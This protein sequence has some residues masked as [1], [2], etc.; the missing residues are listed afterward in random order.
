[1]RARVGL[2]AHIHVSENPEISLY[3]QGQE[4]GIFSFTTASRLALLLSNRWALSLGVKWPGREADHSPPSSAEVKGWVELYLH[5]PNML[6]WCG[7]QLKHRDNFTFAC[8]CT[9]FL[10]KYKMY[11]LEIW[12]SLFCEGEGNISSSSD[13]EVRPINDSISASKYVNRHTQ[14]MIKT[15]TQLNVKSIYPWPSTRGTLTQHIL[16]SNDIKEKP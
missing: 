9:Q 2:C 16:Y 14:K 7:A 12:I 4:L 8:V 3:D 11:F 6:S 10:L 1:M 15:T 5:S 13:N